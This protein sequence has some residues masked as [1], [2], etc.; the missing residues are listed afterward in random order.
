MAGKTDAEIKFPSVYRHSVYCKFCQTGTQLLATGGVSYQK[1]QRSL[2][3]LGQWS[4][5][6]S[7]PKRSP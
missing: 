4:R 6:I 7:G 2:K 3:R 5:V 1:L